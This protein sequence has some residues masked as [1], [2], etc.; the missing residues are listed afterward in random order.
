MM[1]QVDM[2]LACNYGL[3]LFSNASD[4]QQVHVDSDIIIVVHLSIHLK[5]YLIS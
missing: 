1:L 2:Y 4:L 3:L 5:L